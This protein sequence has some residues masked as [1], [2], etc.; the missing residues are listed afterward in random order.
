MKKRRNQRERNA[1]L[2]FIKIGVFTFNFIPKK[3]KQ[4]MSLFHILFLCVACSF[5]PLGIPK[6][7]CVFSLNVYVGQ[8]NKQTKT[9]SVM[10]GKV[11]IKANTTAKSF[12]I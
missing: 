1:V 9:I 7:N 8:T 12:R 4:Q 6:F 11:T 3:K 5:S 10:L 2:Q